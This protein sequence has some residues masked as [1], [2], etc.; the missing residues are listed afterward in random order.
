MFVLSSF[1]FCFVLQGQYYYHTAGS[2]ISIVA[3]LALTTSLVVAPV[4]F[5]VLR[6]RFVRQI[7][8]HFTSSNLQKGNH[9]DRLH[10]IFTKLM[11]KSQLHGV[12]ISSVS[13]AS[14]LPVSAA[15]DWQGKKLVAISKEIEQLLDDDELESV[16]AHELGH[17]RQR[18]SFRRT[19]ATIYKVSFPFDPLGRFIEAAIYREG[20]ISAD[21]YSAKLTRKPAHLASALLKLH[22]FMSSHSG[23]MN[24][25]S[26]AALSSILSGKGRGLLSKQPRLATRIE[27]L[28]ELDTELSNK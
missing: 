4:A 24:Y 28:L 26:G 6:G 13:T 23:G 27:R 21:E 1:A 7:Y 20:E 17:I 15:L 14:D 25:A 22:E 3:K 8:P 18:D 2:V 19:M 10:S 11:S 5:F 16:L 12:T 9:S